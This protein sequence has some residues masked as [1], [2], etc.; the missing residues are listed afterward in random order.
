M[1]VLTLLP[2]EAG[3]QSARC[4]ARET[5]VSHLETRF[6]EIQLS[7]GLQPGQGLI[8]LFANPE[9]GSWTILLTTPEGIS[10]LMAAGGDFQSRGLRKAGR[11]A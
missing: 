3:A 1:V 6:G 8:E 2:L 7:V 5:V 9:S 11:A 4:A 10:C